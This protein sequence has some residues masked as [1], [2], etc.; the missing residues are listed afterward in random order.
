M[1]LALNIIYGNNV[2]KKRFFCY[3][4]WLKNLENL[5][6]FHC[7]LE[8]KPTFHHSIHYYE[9]RECRPQLLS[10]VLL[11]AHILNDFITISLIFFP[12]FLHPYAY[13]SKHQS[14]ALFFCIQWGPVS[15]S[16]KC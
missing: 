8:K 1:Y 7:H 15:P 12:Q 16:L 2:H 6:C 10:I 13:M 5:H 11:V 3:L 4:I 9:K 14:F